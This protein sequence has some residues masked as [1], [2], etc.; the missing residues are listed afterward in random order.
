MTQPLQSGDRSGSSPSPALAFRPDI[1]GLRAVAILLVI[2]SHAGLRVFPS[3]F[4]GVD[5]FFVLSGYLITNLLFDEIRTTGRLNLARFYAR[6]ARRLLPAA[7]LLVV[8]VCLVEAVVIN[9]L[10][11]YRV[12]KTAFAT[13]LYSSN[14]YFAHMSTNYFYRGSAENPLLHTWSLAVEEQFYLVWPVLLLLLARA[15]NSARTIQVAL[16]ALASISFTFCIWQTGQNPSAAFFASPARAWEFCLG[17]LAV[18]LPGACIRRGQRIPA[19]LGVFGFA[20]LLLSAQWIPSSAFPGYVAILPALGTVAILVA[21]VAAPSSL[22]PR[23]LSTRPAQIVGGL[24]Y[25]LYLWH[26]PALVVAQQ[27]FPSGLLAVRLAAIAVAAVLAVLTHRLVEN[28][29]RFHPVLVP[30]P[31]LTLKLALVAACICAG[32]LGG[33]RSLLLH[34]AQ[35]QKFDQVLH[36]TSAV[37]NRDCFP[38]LSD[39]KPRLCTFGESESPR[40]TVVLFGDSHAAQWFPAL[41]EIAGEQHWKLIT[42]IKP[43]CTPLKIAAASMPLMERVCAQ[44]W[45][46]S[47]AEIRALHPDLVVISCTWL[48]S[49]ENSTLVTDVAVWQQAARAAFTDLAQPG[50]RIRFL[51]DTPHASFN[52]LECL[53]Q[54][55]WNPRTHCPVIDPAT[56]LYPEIYAAVERGAA[57]LANVGFIDL[58][59]QMCSATQCYPEIGG[60]IV[61]RDYDHLTA[62]YNRSLAGVLAERLMGSPHQ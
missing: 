51:R 37:Y 13:I 60:V 16:V 56:A 27:L 22:I 43:G 54:T 3:G 30:R 52:V 46:D 38:D 14:F 42:L 35:F 23:L 39:P 32:A 19:W 11:Q 6:R 9:P 10:Q 1:E 59:D 58:T 62:A 20:G 36:D 28:P 21:G 5:V 47:T 40:S 25:S 12:L 48:Y 44:W 55:E 33:W 18:L 7:M 4:I 49:G 17:A 34:S 8:A 29:I 24:S 31:G 50:T 53:A 45:R 26:W 2:F 57:G 15:R 41:E 61:Y